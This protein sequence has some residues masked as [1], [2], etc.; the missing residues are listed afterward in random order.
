MLSDPAINE[1][2]QN[3]AKLYVQRLPKEVEQLQVVAH[4][5][6]E[7]GFTSDLLEKLG[8]QLH[9]IAGSAG[10][11][12][13]HEVTESTRI[14]EN[15]VKALTENPESE[16][17]QHNLHGLIDD[18]VT[19]LNEV[20]YLDPSPN[21]SV[22]DP[23]R[24]LPN[25]PHLW[26]I[27]D[28]A[29]QAAEILRVLDQFNY[30]VRWFES[31][32][33]AEEAAKYERPDGLILDV[34]FSIEQINIAEKLTRE[35]PLMRLG[36]PMVFISASDSFNA[37]LKAVRMG[38]LGYML[39]PLD[40]P[41]LIDRLESVLEQ[42]RQIAYRVL[43]VE[44]DDLQAQHYA[45]ILTAAGM[46]VQTLAEPT[47]I[48]DK[49]ADFRPELVLM[50]IHMPGCSGAELAGMIRTYEEW[51][52]LPVIYLSA[53]TDLDQQLMAMGRG[54]DDFITKTITDTRLVASVRV[55]AAR[56]RK[57]DSLMS[58]D[59]LTG[60]LKHSRI[61]ESLEVEIARSERNSL[62]LSVVM[63]DLDHF[64]KINDTYGHAA[65]D[66]VIRA[67]AHLL[68]QRLRK[69][70][71]I[72]RYG[73]EE[74]VIILPDTGSEIAEHLMTDILRRFSDLQFKDEQEEFHV[75]FSAGIASTADQVTPA[76]LL[77][78]ADKALYLAKSEGRNQVRRFTPRNRLN[79]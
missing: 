51:V 60:L 21:T 41:R 9:G 47:E 17:Y 10:T 29:L 37:R 72:G 34:M 68:R 14:V 49:L 6:A 35:S 54:G 61:K 69:S 31:F 26:L 4:E 33:V 77:A 27:E 48:M 3:L 36:V 59:G 16:V 55:R 79:E 67:M 28:D 52:S 46:L 1:L 40:Y 58:R 57:L 66:Q 22:I 15:L 65:G 50:D 38:A 53:E 19:Q 64:K 70:D 39:K 73:G 78:V 42:E 43:I 63:L 20:R 74:F 13:F 71:I 12:G 8:H 5:L 24:Y 76:A 7:Q 44:D 75:T 2:L 11:F 32:N 45:A 23:P 62:P 30:S 25:Q 18:L 56:F